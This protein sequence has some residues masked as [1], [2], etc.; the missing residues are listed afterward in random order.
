MVR[1]LGSSETT[2]IQ[3]NTCHP[4]A[5]PQMSP[6]C[7]PS[8]RVAFRHGW[9]WW[10][11][12]LVYTVAGL[13]LHPARRARTDWLTHRALRTRILARHTFRGG[14][15]QN[16]AQYAHTHTLI[17][18]FSLYLSNF[19]HV[20]NMIISTNVHSLQYSIVRYYAGIAELGTWIIVCTVASITA[21]I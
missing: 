10:W 21:R 1:P 20:K 5:P 4:P 16:R 3:D 11:N 9:N 17:S 8:D 14:G 2:H 13:W 6:L 7:S 15:R 19:V 12:R 18:N